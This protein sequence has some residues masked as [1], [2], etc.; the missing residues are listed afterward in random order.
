MSITYITQISVEKIETTLCV[1]S[2]K[3]LN[4]GNSVL[5]EAFGASG[6]V[7][8]GGLHWI[9]DSK[10][11]QGDQEA[12]AAAVSTTASHPS[13]LVTSC[14]NMVQSGCL[15]VFLVTQP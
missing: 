3:G 8:A 2:G 6:G 10:L 5:M 13:K 9:I 7:E 14:W 4:T 12:I 15:N 11:L 1:S